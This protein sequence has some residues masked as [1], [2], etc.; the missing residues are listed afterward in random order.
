MNPIAESKDQVRLFIHLEGPAPNNRNLQAYDIG[1]ILIA[2]QRMVGTIGSFE[3]GIQD[4]PFS[5]LSRYMNSRP[6][7]TRENAVQCQ[8]RDA[9]YGSFEIEVA[10]MLGWELAQEFNNNPIAISFLTSV[11]ANFFTTIVIASGK[12]LKNCVPSSQREIQ[13]SEPQLTDLTH[14][15]LSPLTSMV[16]KIDNRSGINKLKIDGKITK[17]EVLFTVEI[18]QNDRRRINS[19]VDQNVP[20]SGRYRGFLRALNLE[21]RTGVFLDS[22]S[23]NR[24]ELAVPSLDLSDKLAVHMNKEIIIIG[25][26]YTKRN[27]EDNA[28][29]LF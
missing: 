14:R 25:S 26:L 18:D 27:V 29:E 22:Y 17:S 15:V 5:S 20:P 12:K 8:I 1:T 24:F 19:F 16:N 2:T 10:L 4:T 28:S 7:F 23:Q 3:L 6:L 11:V 13:L 21:D 9:R